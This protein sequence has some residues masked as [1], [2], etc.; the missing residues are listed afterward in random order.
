[1]KVVV[2]VPGPVAVVGTYT[3]GKMSGSSSPT[4]VGTTMISVPTASLPVGGN[5]TV[6][7]V[8]SVP[9]AV[10]VVNNP[11]GAPPVGAAPSVGVKTSCKAMESV[12]TGGIVN[13]V[14]IVLVHGLVAAVIGPGNGA[15]TGVKMICL[16]MSSVP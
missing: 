15:T 8:G 5:T 13:V 14:V 11:A 3:A 12:P 16:S 9:M 10:R 1:M 2:S 7:V 4:V 6:D